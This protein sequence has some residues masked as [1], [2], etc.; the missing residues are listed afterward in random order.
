MLIG[1]PDEFNRSGE[2]GADNVRG[3]LAHFCW[4]HGGCSGALERRP[5]AGPKRSRRR[6][7]GANARAGLRGRR[8]P[9]L[10]Q[11]GYAA[12]WKMM[13]RCGA[14][15]SAAR[16]TPWRIFDAVEPARA[17]DRPVVDREDH[18][19][20]LAAAARPR[21]ATAC[22]AAARPART[23]RRRNRARVREQDRHLQREHQ[24]A[25]EVLVQAVVV[26]RPVAAAA[27]ASAASGR[28]RGSGRGRPSSV[29]GKAPSSAQRA[30]ASGWR[31]APA[32][33]R[34]PRAAPDRL[35]Q[36][37]ARSTGTRPGRSRGAASRR[38][39]RKRLPSCYSAA[40]ARHSAASI[41][42]RATVKPRSVEI[43]AVE[44]G[45]H[46]AAPR[47]SSSIRSPPDI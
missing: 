25:V 35:G 47:R 21:R 38:G 28:P 41:R 5:G 15:P 33:G 30:R 14:G 3:A 37:I 20:A 24:L 40:S 42:P 18:R 22:A 36:R 31:S 4:R 6:A 32:A 26:A 9:P 27:A 7:C 45:G 17:R 10:I 11:P 39:L 1:G 19:V 13:P 46:P 43:F 8:A 29:G 16:L 34:A 2:G 23:R 44:H 12:S